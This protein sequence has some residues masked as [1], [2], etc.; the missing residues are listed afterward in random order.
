MPL[1]CG[2]SKNDKRRTQGH[3]DNQLKDHDWRPDGH[4]KQL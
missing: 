3:G 2:T 1:D 4:Q